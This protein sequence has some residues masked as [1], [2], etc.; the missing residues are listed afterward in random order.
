MGAS[1]DAH[2]GATG[3]GSATVVKPHL[4]TELRAVG[5]MLGVSITVVAGQEWELEEHG[6]RVGRDWYAVQGYSERETL[7]LAALHLW[8]GPREM[9]TDPQRVNRRR[10]I[11]HARPELTPLLEGVKRLQAMGELLQAMPA[12]RSPLT[13]AVHRTLP[14]V[15]SALPRHLQWI[16]LVMNRAVSEA[17]M[18]DGFDH[19]VLSQ[20]QQLER[21]GGARFNGLRRVLA[22]DPLT[23]PLR[24]LDRALALLIPPYERL[25]MLDS[26]ESGLA[27]IGE[28][29]LTAED[30]VSAEL[31][32]DP[33]FGQGDTAA[34]EADA[35]NS[36]EESET[37]GRSG[38]DDLLASE[39][40]EFVATV[41]MTPIPE[42]SKL[43]ETMLQ[44]A[45]LR[46]AEERE[47]DSERLG[48]SGSGSAQRYVALSEYRARAAA[49]AEPIERVRSLWA[50]VLSELVEWRQVPSRKP[51][52]EGEELA[53]DVLAD[54]VAAALAGVSRP[55]AFRSRLLRSRRGRN[56]GSTDYVLLVDRSA[57]MSG[58]V[59]E[60][61]ADAILVMLEAFAAVERDIAQ[62]HAQAELDLHIRTALIVFDVEATVLKPLAGGV[63]DEVRRFAHAAIRA[64]AGSTNDAAALA[65]AAEQF[66]I[67]VVAD[68]PAEGLERRRI[69]I[70]VSDGGSNDAVAADRELRK[71]RAAGVH[72]YGVGIGSDDIVTRYAPQGSRI[73]TVERL[74]KAL[75][76]IVEQELP[77]FSRAVS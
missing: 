72:V 65:A 47:R 57:S 46:G 64:S 73:D 49:L 45:K 27:S 56:V 32:I 52:P 66:G 51:L 11:K 58:G 16:V 70:L 38:D 28:S 30:A 14:A 68:S 12:L 42:A 48:S 34:H 44:S 55:N 50:R 8:E 19:E 29:G 36:S 10:A 6:L 26:Q 20:W 35:P 4:D 43:Y 74:P 2:T 54:V 76:T 22:S 62:L 71:L 75:E 31:R 13:T 3:E 1:V 33:H 37:T 60:A 63:G 39:R 77:D 15:P 40:E 59:S 7:A 41:F 9:L 61:A 18:F 21:L 67:G 25:L 23:T 24:R 17:H 53:T 69:V 5:T